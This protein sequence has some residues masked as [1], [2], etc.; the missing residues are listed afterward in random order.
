MQTI[1]YLRK[2]HKREDGNDGLLY[3]HR[4]ETGYQELIFDSDKQA[5]TFIKKANEKERIAEHK[6]LSSL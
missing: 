3:L 4:W 5:Q 1:H 2:A 6:K